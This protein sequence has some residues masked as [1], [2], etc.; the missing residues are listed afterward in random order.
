LLVVIGSAPGREDWLKDCSASINREHLAVVN[1]GFELAKIDWVI[2]N[3]NCDRFLFLQDSW[4]IKSA[5]FWEQLEMHSGSIALSRDPYFYGCYAGVY[6]RSIIERI[7]IPAITE[8]R[9]AIHFEIAWHQEYVKVS[10]EPYVLFPELTDANA[11]RQVEKYGR[12][13]L[14]L[15]NDYIA[16]Y[17]GTWY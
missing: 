16:K 12:I 1:T 14:V 11:K 8:K 13:N 3:T 17:K 6:E 5:E 15:E 10:G 2:K 7:G 4:I 9:Q